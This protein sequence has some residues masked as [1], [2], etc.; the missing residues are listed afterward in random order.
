MNKSLDF[1]HFNSIFVSAIKSAAFC[2]LVMKC[3][4]TCLYWGYDQRNA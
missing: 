3:T 4:E 1:L 2:I